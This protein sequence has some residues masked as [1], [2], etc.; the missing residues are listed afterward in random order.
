M[1]H[2]DVDNAE[3]GRARAYGE[4]KREHG[5][6]GK[7][8]PL[9]QHTEAVNQVVHLIHPEVG[10]GTAAS[11]TCQSVCQTNFEGLRRCG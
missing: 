6:E 10:L 9:A 11:I 4:G 5:D 1:E 7:R 2:H 8:G 3:E